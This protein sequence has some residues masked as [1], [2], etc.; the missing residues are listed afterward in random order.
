MPT[1]TNANQISINPKQYVKSVLTD[2]QD[3]L[4]KMEKQRLLWFDFFCV[5]SLSAKS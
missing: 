3:E 1:P 4:I 5:Q 2:E